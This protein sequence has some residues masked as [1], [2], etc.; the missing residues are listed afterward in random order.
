MGWL[1]LSN[2]VRNA[3]EN[4]SYKLLLTDPHGLLLAILSALHKSYYL[5]VEIIFE[6]IPAEGPK[7]ERRPVAQPIG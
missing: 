1:V 2:S 4:A 7:R 6:T 5:L 3:R